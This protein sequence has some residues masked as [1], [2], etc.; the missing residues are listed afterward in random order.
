M[1]HEAIAAFEQLL[2]DERR[3]LGD[4]DR[5]TFTTRNNLASALGEAGR[6]DDAIAALEQLLA[7]ERRVLGEDHRDTFRTRHNHTLLL[8]KAARFDDALTASE[9]LFADQRRV[10]GLVDPLTQVTVKNLLPLFEAL[11][12]ELE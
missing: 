10:L 9:Q 6:I 12:K 5:T 1:F 4:D 7:N 2:A 11:T 3:V 8:W